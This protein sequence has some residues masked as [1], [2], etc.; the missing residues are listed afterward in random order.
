LI[1]GK[2]VYFIP[3]RKEQTQ[4]DTDRGSTHNKEAISIIPNL[5]VQERERERESCGRGKEEEDEKKKKKKKK[6]TEQAS[7]GDTKQAVFRTLYTDIK[8]LCPFM[9][10]LLNFR[11]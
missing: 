7:S 2:G 6:K 8:P 4:Y 5:K 3:K 11:D 9:I 10:F 1:H